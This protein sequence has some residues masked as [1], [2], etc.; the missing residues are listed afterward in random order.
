MKAYV[1]QGSH[2]NSVSAYRAEEPKL[3]KRAEAIYAWILEHGPHTDR[4]VM[5]GMGFPDM[6]NVRPRITE[7]LEAH[8][9]M[10]V[11]SVLCSTTN[12]TVRRVDVRRARQEPLFS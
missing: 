2:P 6:N 9:L 8:R 12:K 5:K 1:G 4:E 11:G 7:L 10:E 3:S